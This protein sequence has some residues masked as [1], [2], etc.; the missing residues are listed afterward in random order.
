MAGAREGAEAPRQQGARLRHT[1]E[2]GEEAQRSWSGCSGARM[3]RY[4]RDGALGG[5]RCFRNGKRKMFIFAPVG[6]V[7][8]AAS[9]RRSGRCHDR[10]QG[11]REKVT[12]AREGGRI[13][14]FQP[15]PDLNRDQGRQ[16]RLREPE[17]GE[18]AL[19][20]PPPGAPHTT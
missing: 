11:P 13:R 8:I 19:A 15:Q 3:P 20:A 16:D 6:P 14:R 17:R 4:L 1:V 7:E 9:T 18:K 12:R 10:S 5:G 2:Y